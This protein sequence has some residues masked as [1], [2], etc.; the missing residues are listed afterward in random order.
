MKTWLL[1]KVLKRHAWEYTSFRFSITT[2]TMFR[3]RR[4]GE[5]TNDLRR[6]TDYQLLEAKSAIL[7]EAIRMEGII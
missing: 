4:C 5:R 3:C 7:K 2:D 6:L 1:C